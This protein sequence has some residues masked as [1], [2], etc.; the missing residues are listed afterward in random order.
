MLCHMQKLDLKEGVCLTHS[1]LDCVCLTH[2]MLTLQAPGLPDIGK[3]NVVTVFGFQENHL[4]DVLQEFS[5]CGDIFRFFRETHSNWVHLQFGV[6]VCILA[7][8][9]TL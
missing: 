1:M 4:P 7:S 2:S 8:F 3:E 9:N 6:R 5:H